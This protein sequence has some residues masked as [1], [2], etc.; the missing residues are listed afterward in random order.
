MSKGAKS[1]YLYKWI[2]ESYATVDLDEA[3]KETERLLKMVYD[4]YLEAQRTKVFGKISYK[5]IYNAGKEN[6]IEKLLILD[7]LR[8]EKGL[9]FGSVG[10]TNKTLDSMV[11]QRD[12]QTME[13]SEL[14]LSSPN[15]RYE[16]YTFFA[17]SAQKRRLLILRNGDMPK[18]LHMLIARACKN[19][20]GVEPYNFIAELFSEK[21]LRNRIKELKK[22]KLDTS[23]AVHEKDLQGKPPMRKL[24]DMAENK[25]TTFRLSCK[26]NLRHNFTDD[27]IDEIIEI[28][29]D[30]D[31]KMFKISEGD[32]KE[33]T[34]D[35]ID[36]VKDLVQ[37]KRDIFITNEQAKN[38]DIVYEAFLSVLGI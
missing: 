28:S 15:K 37:E 24:S 9:L 26:L 14:T 12:E 27:D 23:F 17:I 13:H 30:H 21:D 5:C 34:K 8:F 29:Q 19:S 20:L 35:S 1:V 16:F 38:A 6:E 36:L 25:R 18:N 3:A 4:A 2:V 33:S 7:E 32:S 11:R 31:C 10:L 22:L